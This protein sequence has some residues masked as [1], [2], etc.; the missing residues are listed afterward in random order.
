MLWQITHLPISRLRRE[1]CINTMESYIELRRARWLEKIANMNSNRIPR[2]LLGA[3]LP[4][5]RK[6]GKPFQTIR[7][8]YVRTLQI[9]GFE[10]SDFESWMHEAKDRDKWSTRVEHFL[11]LPSGTYTRS[12]VKCK[13]AYLRTYTE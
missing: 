3:W 13:H 1:S 8:A 5:A 11:N 2:M 6:I 10:N 12:N 9:L 4:Y 7:H